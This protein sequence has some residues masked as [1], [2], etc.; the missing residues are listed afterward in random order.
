MLWFF[1][2]V[3]LWSRHHMVSLMNWTSEI[4]SPRKQLGSKVMPSSLNEHWLYRWVCLKCGKD[5]QDCGNSWKHSVLLTGS[6]KRYWYKLWETFSF[7]NRIRQALLVSHWYGII[8]GL[9]KFTQ[10][11]GLNYLR[12][13]ITSRK[14][15]VG[16]WQKVLLQMFY[17]VWFICLWD[18]KIQ[19]EST[20]ISTEINKVLLFTN[21]EYCQ[22]IFRIIIID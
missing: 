1:R 20:K 14:W 15:E 16:A 12:Q 6:D 4:C 18:P 10:F 11:S 21:K 9:N 7:I 17:A 2:Y 22:N 5:T 3:N 13:M 19:Q 8:K